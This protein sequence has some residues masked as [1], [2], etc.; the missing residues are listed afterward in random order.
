MSDQGSSS[1]MSDSVFN[2][3]RLEGYLC[4]AVIKVQDVEFKIH[5]LILC[6]CSPYFRAL[7][8]RWSTPDKKVFDIP[9]V[10]PASMQLIIEFAYTGIVSVTEDN[11][12]ELLLAA[13]QFNV[14]GIVQ[15]CCH[16][17][18]EHLSP[19]NCI[20][21]WCLSDICFSPRLQHK[22]YCYI[23]DHFEEVAACEELQQLSMQQLTDILDRDDLNVRQESAVYEA[24]LRWIAHKPEERKTH[25]AALLSK[26][27][28]ASTSEEYITQNV[29]SNE[30]VRTDNQSL[31]IISESIRLL[32][33][34][35]AN[36]H[37]PQAR[38]R[39]PSDILLATGGW[40]DGG[41]TNF[42]EAYNIRA[43]RWV[44]VNSDGSLRGYHGTACLHGSMFC[45]GGF[46]GFEELNSVHR[47]DLTTLTWHEA[48]PM[49]CRRCYA[50]VTVL[51]GYIYAIGGYDG[52]DRLSSAEC[53]RPETNQW[54]Q[55]AP[56]H[57]ERS[58]A[59]CTT[60]HNK[61]YICGGFSGHEVLN[62]C[63]YYNPQTNQWTMITPMHSR[64]SGIGVVAYANHVYAVGGYDG[65]EHLRS[66]EA[67]NPRTNRWHAVSSMLTPRSNFGIEV[68]ENQLFAVGGF[69]GLSVTSSVEYYN[70]ATDEWREARDMDISRSALTCCL[71]SRHPNMTSYAVPPRLLQFLHLEDKS[72]E[73]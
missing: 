58:D 61:V 17:L 8:R 2:D 59:N 15:A 12:E 55:I 44:T 64:R 54:T 42:I 50:S 11:A 24:V 29:M 30:L 9:G 73:S 26:V 34:N 39:L 23:I 45:V 16:F 43:G 27:R 35:R 7:F 37:Y 32:S 40:I 53:Y 19:S 46:D 63:E 69:T 60:L 10:S 48:A 51:N 25:L 33:A 36:F 28:L 56:M 13:D 5:K 38:P 66:A 52:R 67:Y 70:T 14:M 31:G 72:V 62:T 57:V 3:F 22:A 68:I 18:K 4:D 71:V 65:N 47:F 20:G 41:P 49:H 21:I 6:K 1:Y